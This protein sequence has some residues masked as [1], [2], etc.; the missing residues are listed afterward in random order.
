MHTHESW[1]RVVRRVDIHRSLIKSFRAIFYDESIYPAPHSYDPE[2]YLKDGKLDDSIRDP[3]ENVFGLG[4]RWGFCGRCPWS[5]YLQPNFIPLTG[6]PR[7]RI[8]P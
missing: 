8:P 4:R 2:R 3:E 7:Y 5:P 6:N 1:G